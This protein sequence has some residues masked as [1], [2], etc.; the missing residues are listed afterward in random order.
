M[1]NLIM[2]AALFADAKAGGGGGLLAW[3]LIVVGMWTVFTKAGQPGWT[4]L[5]PIYNLYILFKIAGWSGLSMLLLLIPVVNAVVLFLVTMG[6]AQKFGKGFL[7][8]LGLTFL[9]FI[10]YPIL[11][12]GSS[13]YGAYR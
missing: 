11:G 7:F 6:V 13:T 5:I 1:S 8:S 9:P 2:L 12:L 4:A 3:V 10:F